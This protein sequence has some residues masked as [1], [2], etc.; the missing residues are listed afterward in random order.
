V[1]AH[2]FHRL[3]T[4]LGGR[5]MKNAGKQQK[6]S[7]GGRGECMCSSGPKGFSETILIYS[8]VSGLQGLER[9]IIL[10]S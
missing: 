2:H 7:E 4:L 10:A 6:G 5:G 8:S 9:T 3:T 1:I